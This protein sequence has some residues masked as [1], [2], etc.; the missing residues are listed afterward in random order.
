MKAILAVIAGAFILLSAIAHGFAGWP[1]M[2][3]ELTKIQAPADLVGTLAAGW[4]FGSAAMAALGT[5]VIVAAVRLRRGDASGAF[6]L[7][8][9]GACYF[10]FG[11]I[12]FVAQGYEWFFL[13]FVVTGLLAGAPVIGG[14]VRHRYPS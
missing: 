3:A 13:N 12:A 8:V 6:A 11:L 4:L 1:A 14:D 5:I 7:R 9:I 2:G 10:V